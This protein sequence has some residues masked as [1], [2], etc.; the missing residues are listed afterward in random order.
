M[1]N[2]AEADRPGIDRDDTRPL[3]VQIRDL[4]HAEIT[5]GRARPG[6]ALPT[7][8]ELQQRFGVSRS[9]VRQALGALVELGLVQRSRGRGSIV[10]ATPT[11]RRRVQ[12]AGGLD[13]QAQS[14]GQQLVTRVLSVETSLAPET[15]RAALGSGRTTRIERLR[16]L[17]DLPVAYMTT[18]VSADTF[19][20]FTAQLLEGNSLLGL[21][22]AHGYVPVGG[23][24]QVQAVA[25]DEVVADHLKVSPGDP[26]LL[27]E[28]VTRDESG[29][30]LE[31]FRVWHRQNTVFDVDAWVADTHD[32]K[33]VDLDAARSLLVELQN[34]VSELRRELGSED[35]APGPT[36]ERSTVAT[37]T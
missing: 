4:L 8:Q 36:G 10:A 33:A 24:R 18:W 5:S 30:G 17:G 13:E 11:L 19:P 14:H 37:D 9:V 6:S 23:P 31:W 35:S 20:H 21:M 3:H 12:R 2:E 1:Q 26:L 25:A 15:A 22:R 34:T 28:G 16:Y 29:Y 32:T 27:L 7:E